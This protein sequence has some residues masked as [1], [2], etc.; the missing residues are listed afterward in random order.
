MNGENIK[1]QSVFSLIPPTHY[2]FSAVKEGELSY[3]Y[4]EVRHPGAIFLCTCK[5]FSVRLTL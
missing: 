1:I 4:Y 3:G 2:K 5:M